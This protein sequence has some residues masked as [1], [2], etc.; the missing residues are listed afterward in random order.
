MKTKTAEERQCYNKRDRVTVEIRDERGGKCG[1]EVR[2]NDNKNG[3]YKISYSLKEQG[4]Y[5]III[6]VNGEHVRDSPYDLQVKA[7]EQAISSR[8]LSARGKNS[9]GRSSLPSAARYFS[10]EQEACS[11]A[12]LLKPF[13]LKPVLSF[14]KEGSSEGMFDGPWGVAVSDTDE[15]AVTDSGNHRVQIFDSGGN[16]LR[17]FGRSGTNQGEFRFTFGICFDDKRNIFVADYSNH[18]VQIFSG[19]G[20]YMG[21]FGGEGSRNSQLSGPWGLSLDANGNIIVADS[22][23]KLIKIFSTDGKFVRKIG[24]PDSFSYPVH[25]IQC[26]EYLIV[27][28]QGEHCIKVFS[29]K[30]K[31]QY[32]FGQQG[33][34]DG[35]FNFPRCLTVTKSKHLMVCDGGNNRIQV[36]ELNGKFVGKFGTKG[37]NLGEVNEPTS[38]AVLSNGRFVVSEFNK[39]RI[40]IY[41]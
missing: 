41:E 12:L 25:C 8:D 2:I 37:S 27:S 38:L 14:G 24:G 28:D 40:Q 11:H 36:F 26:D 35:E 39:H 22:G 32:K 20:R 31:Y 13:Q 4:R 7:R 3:Q 9:V 15:I 6:K 21:M 5:S 23:N 1:T 17:S 19:E 29:T 10:P 34:G 30:G 18:R 16:F 33:G